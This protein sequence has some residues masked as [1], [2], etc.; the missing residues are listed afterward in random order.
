MKKLIIFSITVFASIAGFAQVDNNKMKATVDTVKKAYY[1][2]PMH[3]EIVQENPGNC[4]KCGMTLV[5][6][7]VEK[8]L[9][10]KYTCPMHPEVISEK[11]GRCPKCGMDL[12][13]KK[14]KSKMHG[15]KNMKMGM[16][17][18]M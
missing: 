12:I 15:K 10:Q 5:E 11:P 8:N 2:C 1:T 3:P 17:N 6:K 18:C 14:G 9:N 7:T 4:P 16:M 13:K